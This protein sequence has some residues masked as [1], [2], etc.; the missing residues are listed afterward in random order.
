MAIAFDAATSQAWQGFVTT[1]TLSHTVTGSNPVI[2]VGVG[3]YDN[4]G[5]A[6]RTVNSAS[7]NGVALT[8]INSITA[9]VEGNKQDAELW[10]LDA[11]ATGAHN[12][13]VTLS[14]ESRFGKIYGASYTGKT[15]TGIDAHNA[16]QDTTGSTNSP[17]C[18]V[19][20]VASDCWLVAY[21]YSRSASTLGAGTGTTVRATE[22]KVMR[23]ETATAR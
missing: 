17:T 15:G 18:N 4:S 6:V 5:G 21:A 3:T 14:A 2:F 20:V 23:L 7:Y 8:K 11:P 16:V 9:T 1:W 22:E 10:Y 13:S 19:N 12:I